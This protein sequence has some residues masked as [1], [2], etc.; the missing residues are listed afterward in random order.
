MAF[1]PSHS[2]HLRAEPIVSKATSPDFA[3]NYATAMGIEA[4]TPCRICGHEY[5][6]HAA[7]D[8]STLESCRLDNCNCLTFR[9]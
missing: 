6:R 8:G 4:D 2:S 5:W 3:A 7:A 1:K 9:K